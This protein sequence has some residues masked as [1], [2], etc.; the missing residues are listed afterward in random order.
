MDLETMKP[1]FDGP[2]G[3]G[4]SS[5]PKGMTMELHVIRFREFVRLDAR[6]QLDMAASH[7]VLLRVAR[8]CR[9]RGIDRA[10]I[11]GRDLETEL[12][13]YEMAALVRDLAEMGFS[14]N[15]RLALLHRGDAHHRARLFAFIGKLRGW[16]IRAFGEFEEAIDWLSLAPEVGP[17]WQASGEQI[18]LRRRTPAPGPSALTQRTLERKIRL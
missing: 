12:T 15:Q 11:D 3:G 2:E 17:K 9:K 13:P 8:I 1:R 16:N 10:L 5:A 7:A 14:P 18:P 4:R 6:G